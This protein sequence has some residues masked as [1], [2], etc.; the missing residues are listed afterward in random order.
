LLVSLHR[1]FFEGKDP[2][3]PGTTIT[4]PAAAK[5]GVVQS[6]QQLKRSNKV[7]RTPGQ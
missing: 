4:Q 5:A 2:Y 3:A 7:A 1:R 6:G